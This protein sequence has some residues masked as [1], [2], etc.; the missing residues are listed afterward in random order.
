MPKRAKYFFLKMTFTMS[1]DFSSSHCRQRSVYET[2]P[3][4][5]QNKPSTKLREKIRRIFVAQ[6]GSGN[7]FIHIVVY[8]AFI[9]ILFLSAAHGLVFSVSRFGI[10]SLH[11]FQDSLRN[12]KKNMP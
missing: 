7:V 3:N 5:T 1:W 11:R 2:L 12:L 10:F 8:S 9:F 6:T 4:L